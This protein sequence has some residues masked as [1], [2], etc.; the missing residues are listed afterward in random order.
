MDMANTAT[1]RW[2]AA[3]AAALLLSP[4]SQAGDWKINSSVALAERYTDNV[5]L[6][7]A[8]AE[9]SSFITEL[10]PALR[11]Q[12]K[13]GRFEA[14]VDYSLQGLL[15]S[16]DSERSTTYNRLNA[17]SKAELVDNLL[18][19]DARA[20]VGQQ[21]RSLTNA[22]GL[23]PVVG[24]SG[25][26][27]TVSSYSLSPYIKLRTSAQANIEARLSH[28]GVYSDGGTGNDSQANR[29]RLS[30]DSGAEAVPWT[31]ALG[32]DRQEVGF[33]SSGD[34]SSER[35]NGTVRYGLSRQF[36]VS[37]QASREYNDYTGATG[38][39]RDFTYWGVGGYYRPGR[40]FSVDAS[41]NFADSGNFFSG[42]VS[43]NPTLRTTLTASAAQRSFGRSYGLAFNHRT[44]RSTWSLRYTEDLNTTRQQLLTPTALADVY[45]CAGQ[46]VYLP[47]G[48]Q[49]T[50]PGCVFLGQIGALIA[51]DLSGTYVSRGLSGSVNYKLRKATLD[52]SLYDSRRS[53][54]PSGGSDTVRGLR[55]TLSVKPASRTTYNLLTGLT[56]TEA[57]G[58]ND[59]NDIWYVTLGA[60]RQLQPHL[61]GTMELRHQT[62]DGSASASEYSENSLQAN[63]TMTF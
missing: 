38:R 32:Y 36:G 47:V 55:A 10:T 5:T 34:T 20:Q 39:N 48:A 25:N 53:S 62:R 52:F 27:A 12:R 43:Y 3:A 9:E 18:F 21:F 28:D 31:W 15:Y 6:A 49:P 29:I 50:D 11:A 46:D 17:T 40:R 57:L 4:A 19:V 33:S 7:A 23:D 24:N 30:A 41:Y 59:S 22:I 54:Q 26:I 35:I 8:G 1:E 61:S 60:T 2:L 37:A 44:R 42:S 51:T 63:L 14:N 16:Y 45:L 56:T 13:G 58:S